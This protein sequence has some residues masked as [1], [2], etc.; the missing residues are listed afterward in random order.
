MKIICLFWVYACLCISVSGQRISE[1]RDSISSL[2]EQYFDG[3]ATGDTSKLGAV[4]HSSCFLKTQRDG[5]FLMYTKSQYLALFKPRLRAA[6]LLT[7]ILDID[8]TNQTASAKTEIRTERERYTDYFNLMKIDGSWLIV[9]KV[10]TRSPAVTNTS[11]LGA[12]SKVDSMFAA[13]SDKSPG[14]A[15]AIVKDGELILLK[16]YGMANLEHGI[17]ITPQTVFNIASVSKQFTAFSIYLL[18]ADGKISLNDDIRLYIPELPDYGKPIRIKHLLAHT[19]GLRDQ[20]ALHSLAGS[21]PGD[22]FSTQQ[23]LKLVSRQRTLNFEPGT[24]FGYCNTG[25]TLLAEIIQRASGKTFAEFTHEKIFQP[26]GMNNTRFVDDHE[27]LIPNCAASYER[28]DGRYFEQSINNSNPGPS[29]LYTTAEDLVKW[30]LNFEQPIVGSKDLIE[31]F[32]EPSILDNGKRVLLR[33]S[34][35]GDSIFHAKGQNLSFY[36]TVKMISHGGHTAAFRSFLGR[37]P[38][39]RLAIIVLSNDEHNEDLNARWQI[40]DF[41]IKEKLKE[42]Q[43][44]ND[45]Q[46]V[47]S[48]DRKPAVQIELTDYAGTYFSDEL[49][50]GYRV[51]QSNEKL[52]LIHDRLA[53]IELKPADKDRFTGASREVFPFGIQFSRDK[54]NR[55]S[56][57]LISNFGVKNLVFTKQRKR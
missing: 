23:V 34:S 55:V 54:K 17:P 26:L 43:P 27:Q 7:R 16:G 45:T 39:E 21:L 41:Y 19:S 24:S 32:N 29:N 33:V 42:S 18:A 3:W 1:E 15:V 9:D 4:M 56:G 22:I 10:A 44:T 36:K 25:Y 48:S 47:K 31:R 50:T 51:V 20:A 2:I 5:Q 8:I 6:N 49:M 40:A 37:F 28:R 52:T 11:W 57:F 35:P 30:V 13:Y 38:D 14:A 12:A 46:A 53:D